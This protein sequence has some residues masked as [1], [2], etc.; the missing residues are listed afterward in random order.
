[1]RIL[2]VLMLLGLFGCN[3][4]PI[5]GGRDIAISYQAD[6]YTCG[7]PP[8]DVLFTCQVGTGPP[9]QDCTANG[10]GTTTTAPI[11]C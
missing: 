10:S 3:A 6:F 1:M 9:R 2:I 8:N 11:L 7:E 4:P 5:D